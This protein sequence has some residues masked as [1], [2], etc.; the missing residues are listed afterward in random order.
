MKADRG[1]VVKALE[2]MKRY[3]ML[4]G[5]ERVVVSVS[6]GPDSVALLFFLSGLT[7]DMGLELFVFHL[8]HM[9][10]GEESAADAAFVEGLSRQLGL[11]SRAIAVDVP[12]IV[13]GSDRSPQDVARKVRLERLLS[14]ADEVAA[15]RVAPGHTADDQVETFLMRIIQ[16]AGLSG[17]GGI[18]PVSG[19]IIRPLIDVWRVE[20][21]DYCD[22]LDVEPR[23]DSS[24]LDD[25]YLRNRVRNR[26][27]PFLEGEFG[28]GIKEVILREVESLA[29]DKRLVGE[30]VADAFKRLAVLKDGEV[31]FDAEEF[32]QL[33]GALQRGVL[34]ES[35]AELMPGESPI[36]WRH[37]MGVLGKVVGGQTGARLDLP[38]SV[39][40]EREYGDIVFR[41]GKEG[42]A[43][44]VVTLDK[45]GSLPLPGSGM[46]FSAQEVGIEEV[47]F[48][49]SP[50]VEFVRPDLRF[51]LEVR[52]PAAGDRF[53]PLG[54]PGAKKLSDF[55]TD[56]KLPRRERK[57]CWLV[58]SAGLVVWV[59]GHRLDD[60]FRLE[61][62]EKRA[63]R[64]S[65]GPDGE[66]D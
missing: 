1:L 21:E 7:A 16:G 26:L 46:V 36:A 51:P 48:G 23:H 50:T 43:L 59:V 30:Q 5:G 63:M 28:P 10:R 11:P 53:E 4:A 8:D 15:D 57:N 27:V 61:G 9:F 44:P 38:R 56:I 37:V 45:P 6:G 14:Y 33:P 25:T 58:L 22:N 52:H 60:R 62:E 47:E 2:T 18:P 34:R 42:E 24:N 40:A 29:L 31:R 17:L 35:W 32:G 55:F 49:G 13:R 54:A 19:R 65:V 20:V 64:L 66:Y 41:I 3:R 12:S 39:V